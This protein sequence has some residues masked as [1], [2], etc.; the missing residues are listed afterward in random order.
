MSKSHSDIS[1]KN[2][3]VFAPPSLDESI[4][5]LLVILNK[6]Q[7]IIDII[8]QPDDE[9]GLFTSYIGHAASKWVEKADQSSFQKTFEKAIAGQ[10][11]QL[12]YRVL[13]DEQEHLEIHSTFLPIVSKNGEVNKIYIPISNITELKKQH[14]AMKKENIQLE[15]L[16]QNTND[17]VALINQEFTIQMVTP[18]LE[19]ML[20]YKKSDWLE[21]SFISCLEARE[22]K[23]IQAFLLA[24]IQGD[25]VK[26]KIIVQI[27]HLNGN[28]K[29]FEL[30]A[31]NH[32]V[33]SPLTRNIVINLHDV[34]EMIE[35]DE[36]IYYYAKYDVQTGLPNRISFEEKAMT[37]ATIA[38]LKQQQFA[39]IVLKVSNYHEMNSTLGSI[40]T[41]QMIRIVSERLSELSSEHFFYIAKISNHEFGFL[42][43]SIKDSKAYA[44]IAERVMDLFVEPVKFE[45]IAVQ[46][47]VNLGLSIFNESGTDFEEL[48]KNANAALYV[49]EKEGPF[50]HKVHSSS[51]TIDTYKMFNI[52]AKLEEE[53]IYDQFFIHYQ[54]IFSN[55]SKQMIGAEALIR[56]NHPELGVVSPADFIPIAE[57][58]RK[59]V[60]IGYWVFEQVCIC[61][62][63]CG[64]EYPDF[65]ISYN[66]SPI[67]LL[68]PSLINRLKTMMTEFDV[69]PLNIIIEITETTTVSHHSMFLKQITALKALG[70]KIALDDFGEG[71]ASFNKL[72]EIQPDIIKMDRSLTQNMLNDQLS[73]VLFKRI[74]QIAKDVSIDIIAEGIESIEQL[75]KV[76]SFN[77]SY[78]QGY[79]LSRPIPKKQLL[80]LLKGE[81]VEPVIPNQIVEKR[82]FFR[83]DVTYPVV[84]E[85]TIHEVNQKQVSIGVTSGLV[86]DIGPG[87]LR[88]VSHIKLLDNP[89]IVLKITMGLFNETYI[90]YGRIA[91]A[92]SVGNLYTYGIEFIFATGQREKYFP[93]FTK[94][95]VLTNQQSALPD[96]QT[97][98]EPIPSFF[99]KQ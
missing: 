81:T 46:M 95:Q 14:D 12:N 65:I 20:G 87:G 83:V 69:S 47:E 61:L 42:T 93:L 85:M 96:T 50:T 79:Y 7:V 60:S 98:K 39:M 49:S 16:I 74:A 21:K 48:Y 59:I 37:Y 4:G 45:R 41:D 82:K 52:K 3:E 35:R 76:E 6:E 22:Q 92:S 27:P 70:F 80:Y 75:E 64:R 94:I 54:P 30:T 67:Q 28:I 1:F 55:Y 89:T 51:A 57:Q 32:F 73:L 23:K 97:W 11:G 88:L 18:S 36:E 9:T 91:H 72:R 63:E 5:M 15:S 68:D 77:C 84:A 25:W 56:W 58:T 13:T 99:V 2:K 43:K 44:E 78:A 90:F 33:H 53:T 71:Y 19:A 62:A 29:T 17:I 86:T 34:T 8:G 31:S 24:V 10:K 66:I 40:V 38:K 26:K